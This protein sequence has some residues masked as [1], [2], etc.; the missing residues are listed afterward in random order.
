MTLVCW[1]ALRLYGVTS[2]HLLEYLTLDIQP[3]RARKA[4]ERRDGEGR[5]I[6][7]RAAQLAP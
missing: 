6:L 3:I 2:G 5:G 4:K 7:G 1:I